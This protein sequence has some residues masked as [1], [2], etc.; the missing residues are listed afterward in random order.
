MRTKP[1]VQSRAGIRATYDAAA[2]TDDNRRHWA[3]ADSMSANA[4]NDPYTRQQL[5]DRS[6]YEAAN[7][8]YYAGVLDSIANDLVGTGPRPQITI[9]GVDRQVAREIEKL[10]LLWADQIDLAADLRLGKKS[11]TRDGEMVALQISNPVLDPFLPQLDLK[12][13]DAEQ[14]AT[15]GLFVDRDPN[16]I[17]GV[18][19]DEY[20]NPKE[21]HL[22]KYHP[23]DGWG[24]FGNNANI[25]RISPDRM[26]HWF[27]MDRCGQARGIPETTPALPLFAQ[28]RRFTLAVLTAAEF[29]ASLNGVLE[30]DAPL[31]DG[32][33]GYENTEDGPV[34]RPYAR[35]EFERGGL[36]TLPKG[37]KATGFK[38]EQPV[39]THDMFTDK[40]LKE[41]G[42][43][44]NV[45]FC[46]IAGDS[47]KANYSSAKLDFQHYHKS[48]RVERRSMELRVLRKLFMK[49]IAEAFT[50]GILPAGLP[51]IASWALSWYW[52]GFESIDPLK[53][54]NANQSLLQSNQTTL[55]ELYA[56]Y[57][58]DWEEQ[59]RQ[60]AAELNLLRELG[61]SDSQ[62]SPAVSPVEDFANAS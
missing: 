5:R 8:S 51:P 45:P 28:L 61:I 55:A 50:M 27:R 30:T 34:I 23:G 57:G 6:R 59:V 32:D 60:R 42:R 40:L 10:W 41:I 62:A 19:L 16:N 54:A 3:N 39:A 2:T 49:W 58:Q 38:A 22:L 37:N 21:Y 33:D 46:V 36:L 35:V 47:S 9:P 12:I 48:I 11:K 25:E 14:M 7:N 15:P 1:R 43:S 24:W 20:G 52:D 56:E 53:D 31:D 17:D 18:V 29:A 26:C 44:M 4:A 13:Y